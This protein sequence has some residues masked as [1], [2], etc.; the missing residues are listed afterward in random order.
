M[1][2]VCPKC[3]HVYT[4][5]QPVCPK[6]GVSMHYREPDGTDEPLV[7]VEPK[8]ND[9]IFKD[10]KKNPY[11]RGSFFGGFVLGFL[12]NVLG[13][14]IGLLINR[15]RCSIGAVV[16]YIVFNVLLIAAGVIM[17]FVAKEIIE[18]GIQYLIDLIQQFFQ[19]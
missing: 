14:L 13:L 17:F 3:G 5:Q 6:C 1:K 4:G 19:E 15:R 18:Q 7:P 10:P 12:L 8:V 2:Y 9:D 11:L 16:G